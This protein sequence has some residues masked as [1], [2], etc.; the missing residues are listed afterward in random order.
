M[1]S[2]LSI[3]AIVGFSAALYAQPITIANSSFEAQSPGYV[4][5]IVTGWTGAQY[6]QILAPGANIT[7]L[8][9]SNGILIGGNGISQT[10]AATFLTG[11]IYTLTM[12]VGLP[13][14]TTDT[15]GTFHLDFNAATTHSHFFAFSAYPA[16]GTMATVSYSYTAVSA[17]NG[18][19]V[20]ITIGDY[21]DNTGAHVFDN[22][23]LTEIA[24]APE[25]SVLALAGL[26]GAI[27]LVGLKRR[28]A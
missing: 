21:Y 28:T 24:P 20:A 19:P 4:G 11:A 15:A 9:G 6:A 14:G 26:G 10:T 25:P 13:T 17:D 3:T 27:F 8:T 18:L 22:V 12:D 1:K 2:L 16:V 5:A 7:G 23:T